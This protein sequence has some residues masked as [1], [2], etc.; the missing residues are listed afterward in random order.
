MRTSDIYF[1]AWT[2]TQESEGPRLH[3]WCY[4]GTVKSLGGKYG[5]LH[6]RP[7]PGPTF[8]S[9]QSTVIVEPNVKCV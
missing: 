9:S 6:E 2:H 1:T 8:G 5:I 4:G 7:T 3:A